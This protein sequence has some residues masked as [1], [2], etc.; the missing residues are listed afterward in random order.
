[1]GIANSVSCYQFTLDGDGNRVNSTESQPIND[2]AS[3]GVSAVYT[4]NT[5]RNRLFSAG[6]LSYAYDNE[7][8]LVNSG[9]TCLTFD[10][11]HA[12]RVTGAN[13]N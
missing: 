13:R 11:N 6:P 3:N 10:Y 2:T 7:G 8:Q 4:Y 1:M 12:F 9:G 5:Q